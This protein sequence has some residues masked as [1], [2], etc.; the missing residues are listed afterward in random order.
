MCRSTTWAVEVL[1]SLNSL[2]FGAQDPTP[3]RTFVFRIHADQVT[4]RSFGSHR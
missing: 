1:R 2:A 4:G 3:E